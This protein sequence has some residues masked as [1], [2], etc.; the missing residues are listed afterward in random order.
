MKQQIIIF[1]GIAGMLW[2]TLLISSLKVDELKQLREQQKTASLR[3]YYTCEKAIH[4]L[5]QEAGAVDQASAQAWWVFLRDA[6][7]A[8]PFIFWQ[9][10]AL[11]ILCMLIYMQRF[12][13]LLAALFCIV[14]TVI[15][16]VLQERHQRWFIVDKESVEFRI[17]PGREYPVA[18]TM[19]LLDEANIIG[20]KDGWYK[21]SFNGTIGWVAQGEAND[22]V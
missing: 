17:G 14:M 4:D 16:V 13:W 15:I 18:G 8:L 2:C 9:L 1:F 19:H 12:S 5:K 6:G 22:R 11:F 21:I 20:Q 3:E 10:A 7:H